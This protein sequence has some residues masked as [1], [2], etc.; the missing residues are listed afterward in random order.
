MP[1]GDHTFLSL[2]VQATT[3]DRSQ[4]CRGDQLRSPSAGV[5]ERLAMNST[6]TFMR[7]YWKYLG[8]EI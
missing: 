3:L 1:S 6:G 4:C 7:K 8:K 5:S 2:C